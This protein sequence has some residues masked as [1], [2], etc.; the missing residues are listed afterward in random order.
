MEW[1]KR[2]E[3]YKCYCYEKLGSKG[4]AYWN[5]VTKELFEFDNDGI[6]KKNSTSKKDPSNNYQ[7]F[8]DNYIKIISAE[9]RMPMTD[10]I[11]IEF[12][13]ENIDE[14]TL[15]NENVSALRQ[16]FAQSED[17]AQ[18][19]VISKEESRIMLESMTPEQLKAAYPQ[20]FNAGVQKEKARIL[21]WIDSGQSIWQMREGILNTNLTFQEA[22]QKELSNYWDE[23]DAMRSGNFKGNVANIDE[24]RSNKEPDHS[25]KLKAQAFYDSIDRMFKD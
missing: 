23:V 10:A 4:Y 12:L 17:S 2:E 11:G 20:V 19:D 7:R 9:T 21:T 18:R 25:Q 3:L 6:L 1:P 14:A 13:Y 24:S 15:T 8:T 16:K 5:P 22:Q